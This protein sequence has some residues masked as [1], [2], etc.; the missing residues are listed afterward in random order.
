MEEAEW[1]RR[2]CT[3]TP[4]IDNICLITLID[5]PDSHTNV[6]TNLNGNKIIKMND[7]QLWQ[8]ISRKKYYSNVQCPIF[9]C[10]KSCLPFYANKGTEERLLRIPRLP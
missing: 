4:P 9:N 3:C 8:L 2:K 6:R 10:P 5:L 7:D 1:T